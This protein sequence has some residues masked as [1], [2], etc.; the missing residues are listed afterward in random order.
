[1]SQNLR[2]T[3]VHLLAS[4]LVVLFALGLSQKVFAKTSA[5][6]FE[7]VFRLE[8]DFELSAR[9]P[10]SEVKFEYQTQASNYEEAYKKAAQACFTHFKAGRKLSEDEG[11][12]IID[13]CANPR[14][15]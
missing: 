9:A 11:L 14:G 13:T 12:S 7:F 3:L 2:R 1:M 10:K 8:K 4:L 6:N 5:Q 15:S